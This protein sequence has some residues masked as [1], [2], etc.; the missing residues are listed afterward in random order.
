MLNV[1]YNKKHNKVEIIYN[2]NDGVKRITKPFKTLKVVEDTNGDYTNLGGCK[3][4]NISDDGDYM[5]T[6]LYNERFKRPDHY[7]NTILQ[8][9]EVLDDVTSPKLLFYDLETNEHANKDKGKDKGRINSIAFIFEGSENVLVKGIDGTEKEIL[10][11]FFTY[12]KNNE[13]MGLVGYNSFGF[14]NKVLFNRAKALGVNTGDLSQYTNCNVDVMEL[15]RLFQYI[16]K[17]Q[18]MSL[19]ALATMVGL[20]DIKTDTG[21]YNPVTLYNNALKDPELMETFKEYNIQDVRL[22][23]KCFEAMESQQQLNEL[24]KQT[25]TPFNKMQYNSTLLN[26]Y[27]CKELLKDKMV[28]TESI[29]TPIDFKNA[30]GFNYYTETDTLQRFDNVGV[31]DI[32]SYY[33]HLLQIIGADPTHP[34]DNINRSTGEIGKFK[35]VPD[36]YL[37]KLSKDLYESR[38]KTKQERDKHVK[39]S[40]AYKTLD[41]EQQTKKI[42]VNS[43]YGVLSQKGNYYLLKNELLGATITA[44]GRELLNHIIEEFNGVYGK[45][46]SVFIPLTEDMEVNDLLDKLN[47]EINSYSKE[48][49]NLDNTI[50]DGQLIRFEVD[51]ILKTLI[52]KDKNNYIKVSENGNITLKGG[53]FTYNSFSDFERD[54]TNEIIENLA[55][56]VKTEDIIKNVE[57]FTETQLN[58]DKPLDYYAYYIGLS[59]KQKDHV[60]HNGRSYMDKHNITYLYGFKYYACR[61]DGFDQDYIMYPKGYTVEDYQLYKPFPFEQMINRLKN[62]RIINTKTANSL[63]KKH[64]VK[65]AVRHEVDSNQTDLLTP[66][67]TKNKAVKNVKFNELCKLV[68]DTLDAFK[69]GLIKFVPVKRN[70]KTPKIKQGLKYNYKYIE[71]N[72]EKFDPTTF[73]RNDNIGLVRGYDKIAVLDIDGVKGTLEDEANKEL[74]KYL[75]RILQNID[76]PFIIQETQS[77]GYHCLYYTEDSENF[78]LSNIYWPTEPPE[79]FPT[80]ISHNTYME[81]ISNT[82]FGTGVIEIFQD[83]NGYIVFTPSTTE[84][85]AYKLLSDNYTWKQLTDNPTTHMEDKI[86]AVFK[87]KGFIV[88]DR[89]KQEP[90][91]NLSDA[92]ELEYVPP[93]YTDLTNEDKQKITSITSQLLETIPH[94]HRH[95]TC[96]YFGGYLSNHIKEDDTKEILHNISE[97]SKDNMTGENYTKTILSNYENTDANKKTL[98]GIIEENP[99]NEQI[100]KLVDDIASIVQPQKKQNKKGT[101]IEEKVYEYNKKTTG[102]FLTV[103]SLV[104]YAVN[105]KYETKVKNLEKQLIKLFDESEQATVKKLINGGYKHFMFP[106]KDTDILE[107]VNSDGERLIYGFSTLEKSI[108]ENYRFNVGNVQ[109][110]AKVTL[111]SVIPDSDEEDKVIKYINNIK[112]VIMETTVLNPSYYVCYGFLQE[113]NELYTIGKRN[114]R[115]KIGY[116]AFSKIIEVKTYT[117]VTQHISNTKL[118]DFEI[119]TVDNETLQYNN[120]TIDNIILEL[121]RLN[122][123]AGNKNKAHEYI[124]NFINE[125]KKKQSLETIKRA[126]CTGFFYDK[127]NNETITYFPELNNNYNLKDGVEALNNIFSR[128]FAN[129]IKYGTIYWAYYLQTLC[130][131]FKDL[132]LENGVNK[133][134]LLLGNKGTLKT[135]I[136]ATAYISFNT[137]TKLEEKNEGDTVSAIFRNANKSTLPL[138][139]DDPKLNINGK[140]FK[141][142]L[143]S[144][145]FSYTANVLANDQYGND[146]NTRESYRLT[147][148]SHNEPNFKLDKKGGEDR[149]LNIAMFTES[150]TPTE[151]QLEALNEYTRLNDGN[152]YFTRLN[153]I[154]EGFIKFITSYFNNRTPEREQIIS[155]TKGW[156]IIDD[157]INYLESETGIELNN[158]LKNRYEW[159]DLTEN[160]KLT[161]KQRLRYD[162]ETT[163]KKRDVDISYDTDTVKEYMNA[164]PMFQKRQMKDKKGNPLPIDYILL[165][166]EFQAFVESPAGLNR[167]IDIKEI[168]ELLDIPSTYQMKRIK[169]TSK[170]GKKVTGII[171]TTNEVLEFLYNEYSI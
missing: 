118:Y 25:L 89:E 47:S 30:G 124:V 22:T 79:D 69:D 4:F 141:A 88:K 74:K 81:I 12:C 66:V 164:S 72:P 15:G 58:N 112:H 38:A 114:G 85:G 5:Y 84:N 102:S 51:D 36:G 18:Y 162:Y 117:P 154:G 148:T 126:P 24:F 27:T 136:L 1:N 23:I 19:E 50:E 99:D 78:N 82:S 44:L 120:F 113:N 28:V 140:D 2:T 76:Y 170:S 92:V 129:K 39:D 150:D 53:S 151:K 100:A 33:P 71:E 159:D 134:L 108:K 10:T 153:S 156:N 40:E 94:G 144:M 46:D 57:E 96:L 3:R 16:K 128:V 91:V 158:A 60:K 14:D 166:E 9:Q 80:C 155:N 17:G 147:A 42:I 103:D 169:S 29:N 34:Y 75:L 98:S 26:G 123:I 116:F 65:K 49:Y 135:T 87:D 45:T 35:E 90:K 149:R 97:E 101:N 52:V 13:I 122:L 68:P 109:K 41:Y 61:V 8:H 67:E 133:H 167:H 55:T 20:D 168:F 32:V 163:L 59:E 152:I 121:Q 137:V 70:L 86:D 115:V 21:Y 119:V 130:N 77:G 171:L 64:N 161:L 48:V 105:P 6:C 110:H 31:F 131:I 143:K 111:K 157:F 93:N 107:F 142:L 56:G 160:E 138:T 62:M 106:N 37:A 63:K 146:T 139:N 7:L 132:N 125:T 43:L 127:E 54:I 165:K 11:T 73:K 83:L 104:K 95:N 145:A